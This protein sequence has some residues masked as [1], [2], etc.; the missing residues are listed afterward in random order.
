DLAVK[1]EEVMGGSSPMYGPDN[2]VSVKKPDGGVSSLPFVM[3][4]K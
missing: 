3:P 1:V 4:E 2:R